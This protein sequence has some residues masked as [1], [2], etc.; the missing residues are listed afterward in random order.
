MSINLASIQKVATLDIRENGQSISA[1]NHYKK[2]L[3]FYNNK[4]IEEAVIEL[5]LAV[6]FDPNNLNAHLLL[7]AIYQNF[8]HFG[9]ATLEFKEILKIEPGNETAIAGLAS[10][11]FIIEDYENA[12]FYFEKI[13]ALPKA[14]FSAMSKKDVLC[15]LG[16]S[17]YKLA[18]K[19]SALEDIEVYLVKAS[20]HLKKV[21]E[22]DPGDKVVKEIFNKTEEML[23]AIAKAKKDRI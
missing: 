16:F 14:E 5:Q 8:K 9:K 22:L 15:T 1:E 17:Y 10:V 11:Y 6:K 18:S 20:G 2:G 23:D 7:G 21:L 12:I 4:R 13:L 19:R 3:E